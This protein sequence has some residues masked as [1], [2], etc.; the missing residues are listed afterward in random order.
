MWR[1][2]AWEDPTGERAFR[3]SG[4]IH[5]FNRFAYPEIADG[6]FATFLTQFD[7]C[8]VTYNFWRTSGANRFSNSIPSRFSTALLA[9]IPIIVPEGYLQGCAGIINKHQIGFA[10]QNYTDLQNKL[11]DKSMLNYYRK[12]AIE[13]APSFSLE[14]N[15]SKIDKFLK[16]II[17]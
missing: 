12:K 17:E 6:T 13:N 10:Y 11:C 14:N 3:N 4:F 5:Y 16:Q 15:F 9:G 8:V 1:E 7:A 2:N